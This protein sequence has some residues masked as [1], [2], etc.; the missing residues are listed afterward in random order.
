MLYSKDY[1][2]IQL[3]HFRDVRT[4]LA[5]GSSATIILR[6]DRLWARVWVLGSLHS[7]QL[8]QVDSARECLNIR[9]LRPRLA[10]RNAVDN[11]E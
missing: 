2:T 8:L 10:L 7:C 1:S 3:H 6:C 11:H 4:T 9:F 5:C